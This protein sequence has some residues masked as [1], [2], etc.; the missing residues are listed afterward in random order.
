[1]THSSKSR[2]KRVRLPSG[3]AGRYDDLDGLDPRFDPKASGSLGSPSGVAGGVERRK[4]QQLC[5]QVTR[6]L[7]LAWPDSHPHLDATCI[8]EVVPAPNS[9]N[10]LVLVSCSL[11]GT[12]LRDEQIL[13]ALETQRDFLRQEMAKG[14]NRKRIPRLSFA[15]LPRP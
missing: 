10:L 8:H 13:D 14:I 11:A 7:T 9:H 12:Q 6:L 15:V 5:S 2:A 1:M 3:L 4:L